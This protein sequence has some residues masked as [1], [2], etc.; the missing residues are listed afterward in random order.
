MTTTTRSTRTEPRWPASAALTLLALGAVFS[1]VAGAGVTDAFTA[2]FKVKRGSLG[3]GT[4]TF[5]LAPAES[6]NGAECYI[7]SGR[8]N[9]NALV[10][11]FIGDVTDDSRFCIDNGAL[12]P[13]HFSH[14]M[15]GDAEDSYT[16]AFDWATQQVTYRNEAGQHTTMALPEQALDPLSIQIAAR[17]WVAAADD[18]DHL[19]EADF[20]LVDEDEIKTYTLR[21]SNGGTIDTPAGRYA[22]L[23]VERVD[24]PERHLRFWLARKADWI[25]VRVEHQKGDGGIFRMSLTRLDRTGR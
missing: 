10:R 15:Q 16:L 9:P 19:G 5:S 4:T 1:S 20:T 8:A 14:Q 3:L 25:P 2:H 7:Y 22:T 23:L 24:D 18:P 13:S 17:R 6:N 11:L 21:A 12:R